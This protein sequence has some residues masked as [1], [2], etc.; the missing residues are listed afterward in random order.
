MTKFEFVALITLFF[1]VYSSGY[2]VGYIV[3]KNNK[4]LS[5][6]IIEMG[7]EN[8]GIFEQIKELLSEKL[9]NIKAKNNPIDE[10]DKKSFYD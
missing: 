3:G 7:I 8:R 5:N 10:D 6:K 4:K 1:I 2:S 9:E